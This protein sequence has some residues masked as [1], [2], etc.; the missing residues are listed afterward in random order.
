MA[1]TETTRLCT[2]IINSH[3]GPLTA[4]VVSVLLTRG[5]LSALN[6]ARFSELKISTVRAALLILIQHNLVWH[7]ETE[8]EGEIL[9]INVD[10]CLARLRFGRFVWLTGQIY[11]QEASQII[12]II[13]D[14]GKLKI[15]DV[16]DLLSVYDSKLM[17]T[18][19]SMFQTLFTAGYVRASTALSH[20]S[21]RDKLIA[22]EEEA[23]ALLKGLPTAKQLREVRETAVARVNADEVQLLNIGLKPKTKEPKSSR[24]SKRKEPDDEIDET[25]Y[26][27]VNY[28][29]F[30]IHI[31]N[32]LLEDAARER[33]NTGAAS[34]LRAV[35]QASETQQIRLTDVRSDGVPTSKISMFLRDDDN[36]SK[37]LV[38]S[39]SASNSAA[40]K[41]YLGILASA[42]NPAAGASS[43]PFIS[44]GGGGTGKVYVEFA[45]ACKRLRIRVLE[46]VVRERYGEEAVRILRILIDTGKMDEKHLAKVAMLPHKVVHPLLSAMSQDSLISLQEVPKGNDRN[47]NRTFYLWFVDFPHTFSVL[48]Q[49][50]YKTLF[51]IMSR[52]DAEAA[53]G[54]VKSVLEKRTRSDVANDESL[55][56]RPERE[57]LREWEDKTRRLETL[58]L[59]IEDAV[60]VLRDLDLG[61][62]D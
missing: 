37:G 54:M 17:Q 14:H 34:A 28:T 51:N 44:I 26:F 21:P 43:A 61:V 10:E 60:F 6:V 13:L 38:L 7:S 1:D 62:D 25:V 23:R 12:S 31:R 53:D 4:K 18:Y 20:L 5:R 15:N 2:Q 59:R 47:P 29:K 8:E 27:R 3:F 45:L 42:D 30:H 24:S 40:L 9:E 11:G 36:L 49:N 33:Y 48:L 39:K 50:F 22:Y 19:K 46:S 35:L 56:T 32:Q 57:L 55:L 58:E 52:K 41:E 16:L